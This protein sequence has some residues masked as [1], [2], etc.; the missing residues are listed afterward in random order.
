MSFWNAKQRKLEELAVDRAQQAD[1]GVTSRVIERTRRWVF[2]RELLFLIC[3]GFV[4]ILKA[5]LWPTTQAK[6]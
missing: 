5:F 4:S 2:W 1:S 3:V 6:K